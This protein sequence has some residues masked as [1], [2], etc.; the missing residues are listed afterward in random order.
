MSKK[1]V[2][3]IEPS[4]NKTNV[5]DDYMR[6]PLMGSLYLGTIL[7]RQGYQVRILN[8]NILSR[9]VDPFEVQADVYCITALTVSATRAKLLAGQLKRIYPKSLVI[10]GGIHA[11]LVPAEFTD[12]ADHVVVGEADE[13]IVELVEGAYEEKIVRGSKLQDLDGM[14]F[15]NYGLLEGIE[16]LEQMPV[17]TSRG[18]PFDCNF[19]SV[20]KVF[21]RKFRM[22][23][24]RRILAEVENALTHFTGRRIFFYDDNFTA[25]RAR[26]DE[27]CDLLIEKD[28]RITWLA[29]VRSDLAK[30]PELIEKM[31]KS[32]LIWV[33]VGFESIDD[34]TLKAYHKSQTRS[35]IEKAI[36][37]FHR[38]GLKIHG[39]FMLGEDNDTVEN[40]RRTAQ[41]AIDN[42]IDTVQF[43]IQTP[44]PGTQLY[45]M[46]VK[47]DRI[48][49]TDWDYYNG[50]FVVF[51]PKNMSAARLT[52]ETHRAYRR[53]YS[54][55]RAFMDLLYLAGNMFLD[56]L[57]WNFERAN[58]YNLDIMF[59]RGAAKG[60]VSK[61]SPLNE[62][63]VTY[64][65]DLERRQVLSSD[66]A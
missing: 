41:F 66:N 27:F 62:A 52:D 50:M 7:D 59:L 45:D 65:D 57:V 38:F 15:V 33:F 51:R 30:D 61:H 18:C 37:T 9:D 34:A 31:V 23:S 24:A 1:S 14:P 48:L 44:L 36:E 46:L 11:S 42:E 55:R 43:M 2:V 47:E 60:I 49:H 32:G 58:R 26:V 40:V 8:E 6:L 22:Q 28:L 3:F 12:V 20:T 54:V 10:V 29:Q 39:M 25:N 13:I 16:N 17:M 4:G 19:C 56:A 63:Y 35:D 53:F 5:F 21:G 64:L